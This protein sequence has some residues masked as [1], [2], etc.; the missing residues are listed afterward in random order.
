MSSIM[1]SFQKSRSLPLSQTQS[2]EQAPLPALR[3]RLSSLSLKLHPSI[4]SPSAPSWSF[5][6]SKSLSSMGDYAGS[7]IRKW[8]DW[9]W[10]WVLSRKPMFA[11]DLEMNEEETRVLGCHNKGSWRHVFY[12][13]RSEIKKRMGSD[14]VGLPQT[15]RYD[16]LSY[17]KNFGVGN[18]IYG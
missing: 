13:L 1:Q 16:S 18:K 2:K 8:W 7:S 11:Q 12:K 15:C 5:P 14:K 17:S 3:R 6:R 10:S 4:S 9:G